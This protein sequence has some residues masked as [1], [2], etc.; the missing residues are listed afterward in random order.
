VVQDYFM[1]DTAKRADLFLPASFPV[2]SGGSYTNTQRVV[3]QFRQG[4]KARVEK[5]S[6]EQ[7]L[8]LQERFGLSK[9][10]NLAEIREEAGSLLPLESESNEKF[11]FNFTNHDDGNRLFNDGCDYLMKYFEMEKRI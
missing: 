1:T 6:F 11:K 3:R 10:K 5:L 4:L 8:D 2:E 7:L 9:L